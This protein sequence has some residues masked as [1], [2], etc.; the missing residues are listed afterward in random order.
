MVVRKRVVVE[1]SV[2]GYNMIAVVSIKHNK[3]MMMAIVS[4]DRIFTQQR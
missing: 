4:S 2:A 1:Y 3:Q